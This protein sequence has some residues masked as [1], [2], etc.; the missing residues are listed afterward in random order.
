M[1]FVAEGQGQGQG[2]GESKKEDSE[3]IASAA[4]APPD[5]TRELWDRGK[6]LLGPNKGALLGKMRKEHGDVAVL[7]AIV[8]CEEEQPSEPAGFLI[9]CLARASPKSG[10]G[11]HP[12]TY[13]PGPVAALFEGAHNAAEAYI[14]R[15]GLDQADI[16]PDIPNARPLLDRK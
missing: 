5:P 9:A 4:E 6:N 10:N 13:R 15:H 3:A 16:C 1:Q 7:E 14:K 11:K 8:K 2:Q 12:G